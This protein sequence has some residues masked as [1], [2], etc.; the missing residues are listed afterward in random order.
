MIKKDL[1]YWFY[2]WKNKVDRAEVHGLDRKDEVLVTSRRAFLGLMGAAA[3][4]AAL[5]NEV[6]A[7]EASIAEDFPAITPLDLEEGVLQILEDGIWTPVGRLNSFVFDNPSLDY[8][9]FVGFIETSVYR[10]RLVLRSP[11]LSLKLVDAHD[12]TGSYHVLQRWIT[13]FKEAR[14]GHLRDLRLKCCGMQ[15]NISNATLK[16]VSHHIS[17]YMYTEVDIIVGDMSYAFVDKTT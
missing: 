8:S 1:S 12:T 4:Y 3:A 11:T 16:N 7:L 17:D 10:R 2:T 14:N 6:K 5:P 9:Q 15:M 13:G